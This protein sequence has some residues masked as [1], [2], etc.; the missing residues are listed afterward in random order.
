M[1]ERLTLLSFAYP[2]V[3]ARR[4]GLLSLSPGTAR[5]ALARS[6]ARGNDVFILS[7]CLRVELLW[8]GGPDRRDQLLD[9]VYRDASMA[10]D[11]T[12]RID[13]DAF[14]HL[15][16]V[17][18]GLDSPMVGEME[19]L[20]QFRQATTWYAE[21]SAAGGD[22]TPFLD[23]AVGVGRAAR[24]RLGASPS[25]S[26]ASVAALMAK[27]L[28]P[29]AI[30]GS[31]G[32]AGA[33]ARELGG[34]DVSIYARAP[35]IIAGRSGQ[36]W[37][38]VPQ[39]LSTHAVVISTVPGIEPILPGDVVASALAGRREPLVLIDL[40]M[41]AGLDSAADHEMVSYV[42]VDDLAS[43]EGGAPPMEATDALL[44]QALESWYRLT[45]PRQA[46]ALISSLLQQADRAVDEEV[47]RSLLVHQAGVRTPR[48]SGGP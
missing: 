19:I 7:T 15:C 3:N 8:A 37:D 13:E 1:N 34:L 27:R 30:L 23:A 29:I 24:R 17:A 21:S 46:G 22:L 11:G 6:R 26:L 43:R 2:A 42:D 16:R 41:P 45:P 5:E 48:E 4:R 25:G 47:R 44:T 18:S 36:P 38:R 9:D 40:G 12:I 20:S 32:M 33:V 39:A 28:E 14:L 35:K 31:G 10:K